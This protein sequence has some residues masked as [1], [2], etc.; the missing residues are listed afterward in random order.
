MKIKSLLLPLL[1]L[2]GLVGCN[3]SNTSVKKGNEFIELKNNEALFVGGN[4]MF[5]NSFI[6]DTVESTRSYVA[7]S[8][9]ILYRTSY[10]GGA[11][12]YILYNGYYYYWNESTSTDVAVL[13]HVT[14]STNTTYSYLP[15]S[16]DESVVVRTRVETKYKYD[17]SSGVKVLPRT[18]DVLFN[19]YFSNLSDLLSRCPELY[20]LLNLSSEQRV[21]IS[22]KERNV[23]ESYTTQYDTYYYIEK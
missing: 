18:Y 11:R 5:K 15:Y 2:S 1:C 7:Y 22:A 20:Y 4:A 17:Y 3:N 21:Y 10:N 12:D 16:K 13:G 8:Q 9:Y 19:G 14:T 23:V 6:E